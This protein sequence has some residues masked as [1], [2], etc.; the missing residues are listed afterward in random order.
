MFQDHENEISTELLAKG[1]KSDEVLKVLEP[2]LSD[3][4]FEIEMSKKIDKIQRP[5]FFGENGAPTLRYEIDAY[6]PQWR[7]GLEVEAGRSWM[8]NAVYRDLIQAAVMVGVNFLCIAVPNAYK[9]QNAGKQVT[10]KDYEKR[11]NLRKLSTDTRDF[12]CLMASP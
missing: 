9:F 6:H 3:V 12:S 8:G 4:G 1:L 11:V 7:C 2:R 5:V 10:S